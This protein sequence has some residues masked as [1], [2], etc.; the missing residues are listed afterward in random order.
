MDS[1]PCLD[2]L[3]L[4]AEAIMAAK[5]E[6][7]VGWSPQ[8]RKDKKLWVRIAEVG[9]VTKESKNKLQAIEKECVA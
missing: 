2:L 6:W 3:W 8:P 7:K 9:E 1:L 5:P 4:W